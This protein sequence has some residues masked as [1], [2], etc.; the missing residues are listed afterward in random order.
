MR[1]T[2]DFDTL[3]TI[4][5][6]NPPDESLIQTY[7]NVVFNGENYV[8]TWTDEKFGGYFT[9][10]AR[11]TPGGAV[12]DTGVLVSSG[13]G[14]SEYRP[15]IAYDGNRCLVVWPK[16]SSGIQ[17]RFVNNSGQPEGSVFS[18][19]TGYAGGPKIAY[20]GAN[21]LI[22]YYTGTY[23]DLEIHGQLVSPQG[24]LVGSQIDIATGAGC[25]R[26]ANLIF[27]GN[28]YVVVWQSGNND[29]PQY[30]YGQ[31]IVPDGSLVGSSFMISDN[32]SD[33]RWWPTI[34]A[35]DTNYLVT[36]GQGTTDVWGNADTPILGIGEDNAT[37]QVSKSYIGAT[38]MKGS[39][40]HLR[41][42]GYI[43]FD[44]TGRRVENNQEKPG[45]YFLERDGEIVE[46]II[47]VK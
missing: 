15:D 33:R 39:L 16:S 10:V 23:P 44:I 40:S 29:S 26:W 42:K 17:A 41:A 7:P 36:W 2:P 34:A 1:V 46:K 5:I 6:C 47:K 24:N 19:V 38:I 12:L 14:V 28:T 27:D 9:G 35:S 11:V 13:S 21:Y 32:T 30:I 3:E 43:V 25:H 22:V 45:I 37:N 8:V 18:I 4:S 20:D 31:G